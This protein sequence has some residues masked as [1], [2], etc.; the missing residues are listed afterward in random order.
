MEETE[1]P[2]VLV[3]GKFNPLLGGLHNVLV[4]EQISCIT[5][6]RFTDFRHQ[7][8]EDVLVQSRC[9]VILLGDVVT[10]AAVA[11]V[12][13]VGSLPFHLGVHD[14]DQVIAGVAHDSQVLVRDGSFQDEVAFVDVLLALLLGNHWLFRQ[15]PLN[16]KLQ[17][18]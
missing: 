7:I 11:D 3:P 6:R 15:N 8:A 18:T 16:A 10:L 17:I 14:L 4:V 13:V 2:A 5:D 1:I 12:N 9:L